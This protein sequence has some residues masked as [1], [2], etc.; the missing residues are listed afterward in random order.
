MRNE[1]IK[2]PR[3]RR[4]RILRGVLR[5]VPLDGWSDYLDAAEPSIEEM[6]LRRLITMAKNLAGKLDEVLAEIEK[7]VEE[8]PLSLRRG[9]EI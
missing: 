7:R 1:A 8:A 3:P 2:M 9:D 4:H 5:G 6:T